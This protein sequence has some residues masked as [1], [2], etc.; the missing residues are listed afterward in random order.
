[1]QRVWVSTKRISRTLVPV[2]A[3]VAV[4]PPVVRAQAADPD[5]AAILALHERTGQ[6]H[7]DRDAKAFLSGTADTWLRVSGGEVAERTKTEQL[8]RLQEYLDR[9]EFDT[10]EE[11]RPPVVEFS[12][13]RRVAWLVGAVDVRGRLRGQGDVVEPVGFRAAFLH[14]YRKGDDGWERVAEADTQR[15]LD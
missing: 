15:P 1:M 9:M 13:D 4:A 7:F 12:P 11:V 5:R 6:A 2:L 10:I 8:P 3:L 14:V